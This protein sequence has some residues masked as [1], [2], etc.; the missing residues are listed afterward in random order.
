MAPTKKKATTTKGHRVSSNLPAGSTIPLP[1]PRK[2]KSASSAPKLTKDS[3]TLARPAGVAK[4]TA[5]KAVKSTNTARAVKAAETVAP[6]LEK[7]ALAPPSKFI[8]VTVSKTSASARK[9]GEVVVLIPKYYAKK[10]SASS[11]ITDYTKTKGVYTAGELRLINSDLVCPTKPHP[12]DEK[13]LQLGWIFRLEAPLAKAFKTLDPPV[14]IKNRKEAY[15]GHN[16]NQLRAVEDMELLVF[17]VIAGIISCGRGISG[18]D[19][20]AITDAYNRIIKHRL[21]K[22]GLEPEKYLP[23]GWNNLHS[24]I[25]KKE[26]KGTTEGL[27]MTLAEL[28]FKY[29]NGWM[30]TEVNRRKVTEGREAEVEKETSTS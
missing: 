6:K 28:N 11:L 30:T 17:L 22:G 10:I 29:A 26:T 2:V 8:N 27:T 13:V 5:P 16:E 18:K 23:R 3:S 15:N 25:A 4:T 20:K 21:L 19:F 12:D 14:P 1:V 7:M 24:A 9:A